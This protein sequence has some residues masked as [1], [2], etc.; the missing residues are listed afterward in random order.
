MDKIS[1]NTVIVVII[2]VIKSIKRGRKL[3]KFEFDYCNNSTN[4]K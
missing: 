4:F 1:K 2:V 3:S